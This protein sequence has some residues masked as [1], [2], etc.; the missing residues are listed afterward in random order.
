MNANEVIANRAN[1]LANGAVRIHPND[2]V[3]MCQ[4]SND[5]I[6]A[7][8]HVAAALEAT[9]LLLP[10]MRHLHEVTLV[11]SEELTTAVKTGRTH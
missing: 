4:S 6:P 11:R 1:A 2:D 3:N 8:I 7:A 9:E 10:A 5:V